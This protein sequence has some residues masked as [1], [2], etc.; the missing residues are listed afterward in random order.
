MGVGQIHS[1]V[2]QEVDVEGELRLELRNIDVLAV[3]PMRHPLRQLHAS[4]RLWREAARIVDHK[5]AAVTRLVIHIC[6]QIAI[7]LTCSH[8]PAKMT[9]LLGVLYCYVNDYLQPGFAGFLLVGWLGGHIP[10]I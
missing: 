9:A 3:E 2:W 10:H 1:D 7:V 5:V 4:H 8:T 6:R